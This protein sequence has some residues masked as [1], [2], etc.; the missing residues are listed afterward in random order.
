MALSNEIVT[1][2]FIFSVYSYFSTHINT[3]HLHSLT[4]IRQAVTDEVLRNKK[5]EARKKG[6]VFDPQVEFRGEFRKQS[7]KL[8]AEYEL[9]KQ[10]VS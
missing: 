5:I 7:I 2:R 10:T 3:N 1:S 8:L 9:R 6:Q 4:D